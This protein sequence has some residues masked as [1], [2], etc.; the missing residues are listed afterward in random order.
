M[1]WLAPAHLALTAIILAWDIALAGRIAQLRQASSP[2]QALSGF[3]ALLALPAVLLALATST[4][5][6]GRAVSVMDWVWPF[7][8]ML[9]AAQALYALAQRVVNVV[10]GLPIALYNLILAVAGV[11][12]FLVAHGR[13]VP[14]LAVTVLAA[15][16]IALVFLTGTPAVLSSAL[17]FNM[18]MVSPAFPALRRITAAFRLVVAG[19]AV[20]WTVM[21]GIAIPRALEAARGYHAHGDERLRERPEADFAV[22]LKILPDV[23]GYP[24]AA[25]ARS[26]L[27]VL[28]SLDVD[29]VAVVVLPGATRAAID[30][31]ARVLDNVNRDSTTVI[32]VLGYRGTL[33][34]SVRGRPLDPAARIA[35]L[36]RI[37]ARIH[38]DILLPAEDPYGV[39]AQVVGRLPVETWQA[40][41]TDAARAAKAVDSRVQIGVSVAAFSGRDS[42]LYAWAAAPGSPIDVVG[43][44]LFGSPASSGDI[45]ADERAAD[46]WMRV[47]PP[48]KEHWVFAAGGYPLAYGETSQE[49][50]IWRA[51]VWATDHPALKGLVVYEAGDYG[52][53]RGLRA[54]NGRF[55]GAALAVRRA[56]VG[57][58]ESA[59]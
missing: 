5:I 21:I 8:L 25:A 42:A 53:A 35:T 31:V 11:V 30:S 58:R 39:A 13:D 55:R 18:P 1:S 24:P 50:S 45:E 26:D 9:F 40:Y 20:L 19:L 16:N 49:R 38:P 32:V 27:E 54:P 44:T 12:R 2:L 14:E 28:D 33:I 48:K 51:L 47:T 15:Q 29:A 23:G 36:R 34:P 41:L 52:Q 6:T 10:W 17:Y 46:R 56:I 59:R 4:I 43:F 7:V 57:L 22:G 3:I 37:V